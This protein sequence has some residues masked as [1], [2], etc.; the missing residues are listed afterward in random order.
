[1]QASL[2]AAG[3][4]GS[5]SCEFV[6]LMDFK[7]VRA[8][9]A[10]QRK[11]VQDSGKQLSVLVNNAGRWPLRLVPSGLHARI[12]RVH[13]IRLIRVG[14]QGFRIEGRLHACARRIPLRH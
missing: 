3:S 13:R 6:D 14:R 5:C 2:A 10:T 12:A 1:M 7:S 8:F 11:A 9:A 4:P